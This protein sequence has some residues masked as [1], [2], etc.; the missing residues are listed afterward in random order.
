MEPVRQ[1]SDC[2]VII[3]EPRNHAAI[4]ARLNFLSHTHSLSRQ[5]RFT[6]SFFFFLAS[7]FCRRKLRKFIGEPCVVCDGDVIFWSRP[8]EYA[9]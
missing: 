1:G 3:E 9:E 2:D 8:D 4:I 6:T 5:R 7:S